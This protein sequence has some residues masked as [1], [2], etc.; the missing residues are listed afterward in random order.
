MPASYTVNSTAA[1]TASWCTTLRQTEHRT[2]VVTRGGPRTAVA[3][4]GV[5]FVYTILCSRNAVRATAGRRHSHS[6]TQFTSS[7]GL[8]LLL[9][10]ELLLVL[11]CCKLRKVLSQTEQHAVVV[12]GEDFMQ[13]QT[14]VRNSTVSLNS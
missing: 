9:L 1:V 4:V 7:S 13:V 2:V 3:T 14:T 10:G 11:M 12:T 5:N 8:V 6:S